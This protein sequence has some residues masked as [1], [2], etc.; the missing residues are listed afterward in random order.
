MSV[1]I[2]W[3]LVLHPACQQAA[4]PKTFCRTSPA[5]GCMQVLL[6]C[7]ASSWPFWGLTLCLCPRGGKIMSSQWDNSVMSIPPAGF[8]TV[9]RQRQQKKVLS[10]KQSNL[11]KTKTT[12]AV[13]LINLE[14]SGVMYSWWRLLLRHLKMHASQFIHFPQLPKIQQIYNE[15]TLINTDHYQMIPPLLL[16]LIPSFPFLSF[17]F[18]SFPFLSFPSLPATP[19]NFF[20]LSE[21]VISVETLSPGQTFPPC[22]HTYTHTNAR[23]PPSTPCQMSS[24]RPHTPLCLLP[25][26]CLTAPRNLFP[27]SPPGSAEERH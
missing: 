2:L 14:F 25:W 18:L 21:T 19:Q 16:L 20:F 12:P 27:D 7:G 11:W 13:W 22:A 5:S 1:R 24:P 10:S 3:K 15:S 23:P 9:K 17:P 8:S 6:T 26:K 4:V